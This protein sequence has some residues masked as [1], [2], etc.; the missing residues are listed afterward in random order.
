MDEAVTLASI[1]N[2]PLS[3]ESDML[4]IRKEMIQSMRHRVV[5]FHIAM[6]TTCHRRRRLLVRDGRKKNE[7]TTCENHVEEN[8]ERD[9]RSLIYCSYRA[10]ASREK[11]DVTSIADGLVARLG[12]TRPGGAKFSCACASSLRRARFR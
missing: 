8:F 6:Y 11:S 9:E 3:T 12:Q 2:D 5:H 7:I 10:V 1:G 4:I